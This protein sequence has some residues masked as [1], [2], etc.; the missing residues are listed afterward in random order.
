MKGKKSVRVS[1]RSA[2]SIKQASYSPKHIETR[3]YTET[4]GVGGEKKATKQPQAKR[5]KKNEKKKKRKKN[6]FLNSQSSLG[7]PYGAPK[8]LLRK[9]PGKERKTVPFEIR[10]RTRKKCYGPETWCNLG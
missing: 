2:E 6:Q 1:M 3:I 7:N 8:I 5:K 10:W 9:F 4:G